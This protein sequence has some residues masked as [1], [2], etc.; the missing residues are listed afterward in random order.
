MKFG[1]S[2]CAKVIV[3]RAKFDPAEGIP[4][5][6][7]SITDVETEIAYKNLEILQTN[8]IMQMKIDETKQA[9]IK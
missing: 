3:H 4:T 2:K 8:E 1:F 9:Y 7:G 6:M 5:S